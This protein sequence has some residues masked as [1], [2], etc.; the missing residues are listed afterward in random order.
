MLRSEMYCL[1]IYAIKARKGTRMLIGVNDYKLILLDTNA[2]K[3]IVT[4]TNMSGKG[5]LERFFACS[6]DAYVPCFSIYNVI[7][8]MP[9][10][11]IYE[12]FLEF[13]STIPCLVMFPVKSIFQREVECYL[14]GK[15]FVIDGHI[16]NAF[17]PLVLKDNYNCKNFFENMV[18]DT[19]LMENTQNEVKKFSSIATDWENRRNRTEKMLKAQ[20]LPLNMINEKFYRTQ[21]KDTIIKDLMNYGISVPLGVE[22]LHLPASR[23]ME[24][25]QFVRIYQTRKH[26]KP[27]DVMDVQISCIIPYVNAVITE[28]FQADVYKKAKHFI[29]QLEELEIYTLKDIRQ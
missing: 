11:N 1:K 8:L 24:F 2:L 18:K 23:M 22:I 19:T 6:P 7:E 3:E 15:S 27:N 9:Y 12:K 17:T 20:H 28:N 13:F 29:P 5:F 10:Q 26:I 16:A 21:E 14:E 4:N 25:S